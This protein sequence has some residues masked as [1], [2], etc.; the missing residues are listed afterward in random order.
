MAALA[1]TAEESSVEE[2][3]QKEE[4]LD[5]LKEEFIKGIEASEAAA[6]THQADIQVS[7]CPLPQTSPSRDSTIPCVSRSIWTE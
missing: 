5:K 4:A 6:R 3:Q 7:G 2:S 1:E